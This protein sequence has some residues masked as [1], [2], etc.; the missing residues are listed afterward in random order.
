MIKHPKNGFT[1]IEL[2]VVIAIIA[3]LA[4][5]L[6]PAL[7]KAKERANRTACLNNNKQMGIGTQQFVE[8]TSQGNSIFVQGPLYPGNPGIYT[9]LISPSSTTPGWDPGIQGQMAEDDLNYLHGVGPDS[10]SYVPALKTFTCPSTK[11]IIDPAKKTS[12]LWNGRIIT[13]WDQLSNKATDKMKQDGHSYEVFG[14]WHTYAA[15][16]FPRKT[17]A[18]VQTR[19]LKYSVNTKVHPEPSGVDGALPGPANTFTIMDRLED[20]DGPGGYSEN[21]PN[22]RDGHGKDGA[23]VSFCDG[24]AAYVSSKKWYDVYSLSEDDSS[25]N[26]KDP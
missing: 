6:L 20:H 19:R 3:I 23:V 17:E 7:Q 18:K 13:V 10:P 4:G 26:G 12:S 21:A 11:N 15:G 8:D 22:P 25:G 5:M 16:T 14:Y 24:H 1:L 2:L 9:G